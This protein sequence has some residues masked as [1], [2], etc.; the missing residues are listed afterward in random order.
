MKTANSILA[1]HLYG[2]K[3]KKLNPAGGKASPMP[4]KLVI[5]PG[6]YSFGG[7]SFRMEKEGLYRFFNMMKQNLQRVV[8]KKDPVALISGLCWMQSHGSRDDFKSYEELL[9]IAGTKKLIMTCG[10]FSNFVSRLINEHGI[11]SRVVGM[12]TLLPPTGYDDGHV[13]MEVRIGGRWIVLDPDPHTVYRFRGRRLSLA[14]LIIHVRRDDYEIERLANS[15]DL[16]VSDFHNP[17][18][19]NNYDYGLICETS[20]AGMP[21]PERSGLRKGLKRVCMVPRMVEG[22]FTYS[23]A[24]DARTLKKAKKRHPA[25]RFLEWDEFLKKFYPE[26]G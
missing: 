1:Y 11:K 14:E 4:A 24:P 8:Y 19:H 23:S 22:G 9:E 6:T 13:T 16:A 3:V 26:R 12:A 20:G 5:R 17:K 15:Y 10:P 7:T 25:L 2:T 18:D 21:G